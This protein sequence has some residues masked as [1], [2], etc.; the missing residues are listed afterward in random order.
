MTH[1]NDATPPRSRRLTTLRIARGSVRRQTPRV[2]AARRL[3]WPLLVAVLLFAGAWF[4]AT[5]R[6]DLASRWLVF[7]V[8]AVDAIMWTCVYAAIVMTVMFVF[9]LVVERRIRR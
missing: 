6:P 3:A 9:V 4:V 1:T 2:R 7:G 8:P 5:A